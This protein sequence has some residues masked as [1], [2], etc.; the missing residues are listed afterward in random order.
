[1]QTFIFAGRPQW[2]HTP[3]TGPAGPASG[4]PARP[5]HRRARGRATASGEG[6]ARSWRR[7]GRCA[8]SI[9]LHQSAINHISHTVHPRS[10]R[11]AATADRGPDT[12]LRAA[13]TPTIQPAPPP[14]GPRHTRDRRGDNATHT[15]GSAAPRLTCAGQSDAVHT[16]TKPLQAHETTRK[17]H[18]RSASHT[19]TR[20][21]T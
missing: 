15:L 13:G 18:P 6:L 8:S 21:L 16:H 9:A 17:T 3:Q 20:S 12:R 11:V 4:G 5:A 14:R 1:M 2:P 7:G 19:H 10:G